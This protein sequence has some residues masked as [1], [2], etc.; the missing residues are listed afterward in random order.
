MIIEETILDRSDLIK[1]RSDKG[2]LIRNDQTGNEYEEAI[3]LIGRYT[4]TETNRPPEF[5]EEPIEN[6]EDVSRKMLYNKY[7]ELICGDIKEPDYF[8]ENEPEPDYFG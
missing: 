4:Y 3:D 2:Y 1:R 7:M 6:L 8:N 5:N